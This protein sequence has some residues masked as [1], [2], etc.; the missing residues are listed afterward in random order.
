MRQ[1]IAVVLTLLATLRCGW[2]SLGDTSEIVEDMYGNI[3]QRKLRDDGSVS[4]LYH[5][6]RY[7]YQVTF[8]DGHS[9]AE[10]YLHAKGTDLSDKEIARFLKANAGGAKWIPIGAAN[11]R[12]FRRSDGKA[13]AM[14]E[15]LHGNPAFTVREL[16]GHRGGESDR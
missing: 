11:E 13:E 7:L 3:V 2:A 4:V 6:D 9:V 1:S 16:G 12:R 8:A 10:S 15:T 14:H 5:K